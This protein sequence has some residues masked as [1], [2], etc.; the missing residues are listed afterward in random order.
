VAG[1]TVAVVGNVKSRNISEH[2]VAYFSHNGIKD[3]NFVHAVG[4]RATGEKKAT[5][6]TTIIII[7]DV[8]ILGD[9]NVIKKEVENILKYKFLAR[10]IQRMWNVKEKV[11]PVIIGRVEPFKIT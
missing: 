2:R 1:S 9:R 6:I 5:V 7:I 4:N 3:I 8:A 10:E 11:I